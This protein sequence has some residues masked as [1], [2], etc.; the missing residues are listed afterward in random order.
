MYICKI[1]NFRELFPTLRYIFLDLS[2]FLHQ[3]DKSKKDAAS[4]RAKKKTNHEKNSYL[5]CTAGRFDFLQQKKQNG[6][7]GRD[8]YNGHKSGTFR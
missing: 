3:N 8:N 2:F 7:G 6:E 5:F 4:I 1:N